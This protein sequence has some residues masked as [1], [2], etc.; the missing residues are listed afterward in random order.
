VHLHVI[1]MHAFRL[2]YLQMVMSVKCK[3]LLFVACTWNHC[4]SCGLVTSNT[5]G[6]DK[7]VYT[8]VSRKIWREYSAYGNT[9]SMLSCLFH[10]TVITADRL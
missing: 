8:V 6:V 4:H 5:R 2:R 1:I 10:S 7:N 3:I 9:G